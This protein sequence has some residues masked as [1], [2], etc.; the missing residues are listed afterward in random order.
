MTYKALSLYVV[1][2]HRI[3]I[4]RDPGPSVGEGRRGAFPSVDAG[5]SLFGGAAQ[6]LTFAQAGHG[7]NFLVLWRHVR[8]RPRIYRRDYPTDW[9]CG[10]Q[11]CLADAMRVVAHGVRLAGL[12]RGRWS[13]E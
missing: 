12:A 6:D 3:D 8:G 11:H 9:R 5:P 1:R 4:E 10:A 2:E 7:R 13:S